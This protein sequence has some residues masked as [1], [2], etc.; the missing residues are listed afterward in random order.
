MTKD[1]DRD[2]V[3]RRLSTRD[4]EQLIYRLAKSRQR[5]A[6]DIEKFHGINDECDQLLMNRKQVTIRWRDYSENMSIGEFDHRLILI[7]QPFYGSTQRIT[8]E[9]TVAALKKMKAGKAVGSDDAEAELWM[10]RFWNRRG[11]PTKFFNEV[12]TEQRT[13]DAWQRSTTVPLWKGKGNLIMRNI[14][15]FVCC[16]IQ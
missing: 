15:K 14:D 9:E 7:A 3:S 6:E 2:E 12:V 8:T 5:K 11:W 1:H 16:L 4:G 10:S 13:P